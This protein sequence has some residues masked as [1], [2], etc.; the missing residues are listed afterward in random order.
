MYI[1]LGM[2]MG[3]FP[4]EL[5]KESK[6]EPPP[7]L[8]DVDDISGVE[9]RLSFTFLSFPLPIPESITVLIG[10]DVTALSL[11]FTFP[12]LLE[13]NCVDN[14]DDGDEEVEGDAEVAEVDDE[15]VVLKT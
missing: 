9:V 10:V 7:V 5:P 1:P 8:R 11:L 2:L 12:M 13:G 3:L 6:P 14:D 4:E 15:V